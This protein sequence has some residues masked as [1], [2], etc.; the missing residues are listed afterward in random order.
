MTPDVLQRRLVDF[1]AAA[2]GYV[3]GS[4]KDYASTHIQNQLLRSATSAASNYAEARSAVTHRDF[5]HRMQLCL[6]ELRES[7]VWLQIHGK[8]LAKRP[9]NSLE[10]ECDELIA[11]FVASIGTAKKR[12][13][14]TPRRA[15]P[16]SEP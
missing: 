4:A 15:V 6:K 13:G 12:Q 7:M 9:N 10:P 2:C 8:Q 3:R 16:P 11:I 5:L 14:G 1:A